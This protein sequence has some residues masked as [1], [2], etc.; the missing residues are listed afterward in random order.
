MQSWVL[1]NS[2][3]DPGSGVLAEQSPLAVFSPTGEYQ[4][5]IIPSQQFNFIRISPT[6]DGGYLALYRVMFMFPGE[7]VKLD[8][9]FNLVQ[10]ISLNLSSG[11]ALFPD[12]VLL[13]NGQMLACGYTEGYRVLACFDLEGN[14]IWHRSFVSEYGESSL[15]ISSSGNIY[16]HIRNKVLVT[17]TAGDSLSYTMING[18]VP[19]RVFEHNNIYY[20]AEQTGSSLKIYNLGFNAQICDPQAP[21]VT[22]PVSYSLGFNQS[23]SVINSSDGGFVF[24]VQSPLGEVQKYDADFNLLWASDNVANEI[25]SV[26]K[27]PIMEL[28]NGD[29][30][31]SC[32]FSPYGN[33]SYP[34]KFALV[35]I[36][37]AGVPVEDPVAPPQSGLEISP[38]PFKGMLSL[39]VKNKT[40]SRPTIKVYN[41]KGQLVDTIMLDNGQASWQPKNMATGVYL[42]K[43]FEGGKAIE[44]RKVTYVK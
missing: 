22:I 12:D 5:T 34:D 10:N 29:F 30:L 37:S 19:S 44:S 7:L 25:V 4:T 9:S 18:L 41:I 11:L 20:A 31:Y 32:G 8:S 13:N 39:F 1:Y 23:F 15:G 36:T 33:N 27:H 28:V 2:D 17:S 38:N 3:P 21:L 16:C 35:R 24:L 26:L 42:L 40:L 6:D 14:E 43:L